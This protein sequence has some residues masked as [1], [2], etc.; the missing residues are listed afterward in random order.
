MN[1]T[2]WLIKGYNKTTG[3][4]EVLDVFETVA[5]GIKMRYQYELAYGSN[6]TIT[7]NKKV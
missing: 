4:T 3:K 5:E 2:Q 6:W 1:N 7:L